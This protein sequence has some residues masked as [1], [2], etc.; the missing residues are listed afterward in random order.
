[1]RIYLQRQ[2]SKINCSPSALAESY[3]EVLIF[4]C[5]TEK[6]FMVYNAS[7]E[8]VLYNHLIIL[9]HKINITA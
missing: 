2:C 4:N 5:H 1:M 7:K 8:S 3:Y 9:S 6:G